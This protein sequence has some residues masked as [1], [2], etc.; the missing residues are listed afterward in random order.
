MKI[1]SIN[2]QASGHVIGIVILAEDFSKVCTIDFFQR[3]DNFFKYKTTMLR[4]KN[5]DNKC[6]WVLKIKT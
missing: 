6:E 2:R 5:I 3:V 4:D 1:F